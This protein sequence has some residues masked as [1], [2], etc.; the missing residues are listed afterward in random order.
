MLVLVPTSTF[1]Q[2]KQNIIVLE[3]LMW[4]ELLPVEILVCLIVLILLDRFDTTR[5]IEERRLEEE[6][7]LGFF[8][9]FSY[10]LIYSFIFSLL[11]FLDGIHTFNF[12]KKI[13]IPLL[14]LKLKTYFQRFLCHLF[15]LVQITSKICRI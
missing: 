8:G 12:N 6:G 5:E 15:R 11:L 13:Q 14:L 1:Y 7:R 10:R 2:V 3:I 4:V 9:L